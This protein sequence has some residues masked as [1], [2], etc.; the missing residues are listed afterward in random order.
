V[1]LYGF[2]ISGFPIL[3]IEW[4]KMENPDLRKALGMM[5][6]QKGV[7][8]RRV[9]PTAPAAKQLQSSDILLSFDSIDVANDGTVPFRH[10]ERIGFSYLVSQKYTG[11]SAR[12]RILRESKIKE[13]DIHL[14]NHNRLVPAHIKGKPP[15]Y[16]I[17]AGIVFAAISVPY[18]R[19]EVG[20]TLMFSLMFSY[21]NN[22]CGLI[23]LLILLGSSEMDSFKQISAIPGP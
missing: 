11:E 9:E 19:S 4:Q 13:C 8:I 16:Y 22:C 3:G 20:T 10:G 15:A 23:I 2:V 12:V 18:L 17:L 14:A 5:A 21:T 7:R 1:V 6:N